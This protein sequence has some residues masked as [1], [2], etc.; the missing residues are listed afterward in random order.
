MIQKLWDRPEYAPYAH[1]WQTRLQTLQQRAAYYDGSVYD[2]TRRALQPFYSGQWA[3][4]YKGIKALYL[5]LQRAVQVDV[6]IVP[7]GWAFRADAPAAWTVARDQVFQWSDWAIDGPLLVHYGAQY[8]VSGLMVADVPQLQRVIIRPVDPCCFMTVPGGLYDTRP[9]LAFKIETRTGDDGQD[10]E[11]AEVYTPDTIR[12][13]RNGEPHGFDG[14]ASA[15]TNNLGE[16]PFVEIEHIKSGKPYGEAT[17]QHAI[18][19]LNEVN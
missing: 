2:A 13:Y 15:Y 3:K 10:Y 14:R 11:Y 16:V 5:P 18:P 12:T 8:G 1:Q 17:Y 6:G 4:L 19:L 7:G 9:A